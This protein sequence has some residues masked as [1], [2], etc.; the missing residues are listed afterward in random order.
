MLCVYIALYTTHTIMCT[1][2]FMYILKKNKRTLNLKIIC[3]FYI[4]KTNLEK[5]INYLL[6]VSDLC[7]IK[8]SNY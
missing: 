6:K 1:Y 8:I 2:I 5:V 3:N 4:I 7:L